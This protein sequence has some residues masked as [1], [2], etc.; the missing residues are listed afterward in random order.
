MII[1]LKKKDNKSDF[2]ERFFQVDIV[3]VNGRDVVDA[4]L[5]LLNFDSSEKTTDPGK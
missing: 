1:I 2:E 4:A 5:C 3:R